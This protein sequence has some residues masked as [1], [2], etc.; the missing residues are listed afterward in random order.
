MITHDM[1][2]ARIASRIVQ[3]RDGEIVE[4]QPAAA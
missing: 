4:D 1:A 2:L 3:L